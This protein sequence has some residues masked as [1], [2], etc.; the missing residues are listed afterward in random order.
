MENKEEIA[1][2][3]FFKSGG[4]TIMSLLVGISLLLSAC[5]GDTSTP[6]AVPVAPTNTAA[7]AVATNTT[8]PPAA[9]DTT[10]PVAATNTSAPA[11]TDTAMAPAATD[12]AMA[13]AA[14]A[15]EAMTGTTPTT[16][17]ST[18][19]KL[20]VGLVTDV[21]S[22]NDKSFNQSSYEGV[23]QAQKE[24]G[25]DIKYLQPKDATEYSK[26]IDQ[27]VQESYDVIVTVGF[28]LADATTA[29]AKANPN[30]KFIGVDQFQADPAIPNLSGLV[31]NED[32]AGYLVGAL[33][34]QVSK[35]H[36]IGAVCGTDTVP[37]VWRYCEGYKAGAA[38]I[39]PNTKVQVVY[40]S[41]VDISKTFND[42]AWGKTT[43]LSMINN[44]ADIVFG[45]GGNTGNGALFAAADQKAKGILAIGVDSDQYFT[46]PE[47]DAVL[48]SSAMK[49][50][51]PG[52][53]A[54]IKAVQD[55]TFKGGNN[56]GTVGI[57]PYHDV[58]AQVPAAV[59]TKMD[60]LQADMAAGKIKTGVAPAK[61]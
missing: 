47:A 55:G 16:G 60:Q 3:K 61:P 15:T 30:V 12:T 48:L 36:N 19:K 39:D 28:A 44:G 53:F 59:K 11:A 23:L 43:A 57:A 51:T 34:A 1:L 14:T 32:Q 38:A 29:A 46:V 2:Y 25:A 31:F 37:P 22:V 17:A 56:Y 40:H 8:A 5:G 35:T 54:Q 33:A 49:L 21:G 27:F 18:G 52:V 58:D 20:K 9:T 41:D 6:T 45:A 26:L 50:L 4:L 42:P 7:A 10:A 24:L 13:P